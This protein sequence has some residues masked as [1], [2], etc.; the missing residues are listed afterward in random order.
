M[1]ALAPAS[2]VQLPVLGI[3]RGYQAS[4]ADRRLVGTLRLVQWRKGRARTARPSGKGLNDRACRIR[5]NG[6]FADHV[7]LE[8]SAVFDLDADCLRAR[9]LD[10]ADVDARYLAERFLEVTNRG[11]VR[12]IVDRATV[13]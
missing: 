1:V 4:L 5:Q 3:C 8:P 9:S 10:R 13:Q 7:S 11:I 6:R 2:V 12:L